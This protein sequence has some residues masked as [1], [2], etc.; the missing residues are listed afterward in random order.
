MS[1]VETEKDIFDDPNQGIREEVPEDDDA[2]KMMIYG[3]S[4]VGKTDLLGTA[5]N[6]PRLRPVLWIDLEGGTR[7]IRSKCRYLKSTPELGKPEPGKI[8][9]IRIT[10]WR[11]MQEIYNFLFDARYQAKR[12]VYKS[13]CMDSLTEINYLCLR[14]A[15][16]L[17]TTPKID[18]T[19]PEQRDYLKASTMMKTMLRSLR[20]LEG[21]NVFLSALPQLK[22]EDEG[23]SLAYLKP[24]LIGKL[25]DEAVAIVEFTGYLRTRNG[26]KREIIFQPE[27]RIIAKERSERNSWIG[28]IEDPTLTKILDEI[29][30]H[31]S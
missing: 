1:D 7:T 30:K 4:G 20:D 26:S 8:D 22:A 12:E 24:S 17:S 10:Q 25:A 9:V 27:G 18:P 16:G 6:D 2:V 3:N 14:H 5:I 15:Q 13:L 19:V 23:S 31:Q 28:K 29:K 21:L 11:Q